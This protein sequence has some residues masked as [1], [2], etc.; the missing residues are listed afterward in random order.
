MSAPNLP[1]PDKNQIQY[2]R[3]QLAHRD[4]QLEHVRLER[5]TNLAQEEKLLAHLRPLNSDA[6]EWK[7]RVVS[8]TEQ[9]LA[10]KSAE[11]AQMATDVQKTMDKQFQD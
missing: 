3:A 5:N 7:S 11:T 2:L 10:R 6:K 9:V 4:A 8:E 1:S